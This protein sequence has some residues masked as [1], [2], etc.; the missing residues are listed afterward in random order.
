MTAYHPLRGV[1]SVHLQI[2]LTGT[3]R[4]C[5][6]WSVAG[7]NQRKVIEQDPYSCKLAQQGPWPV[8]KRFIRD[9]VWRRR[10][11]PGCRIVRYMAKTMQHTDSETCTTDAC[12]GCGNVP[13]HARSSANAALDISLTV[14]GLMVNQWPLRQ[15]PTNAPQT[16]IGSSRP[17]SGLH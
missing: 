10:S 6:S 8:Q 9:H 14:T 2:L 16:Y 4:Q 12:F 13:H 15:W 3:C 11:K 7:H 17:V 5:G 1:D